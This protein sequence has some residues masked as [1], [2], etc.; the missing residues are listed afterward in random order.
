MRPLICIFERQRQSPKR[1]AA[2]L[3][4]RESPDV[5][6]ALGVTV[7]PNWVWVYENA[8]AQR[9]VGLSGAGERYLSYPCN[10]NACAGRLD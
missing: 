9:G 7:A 4:M 10:I 2:V 1:R 5:D 3:L 8:P 6:Y